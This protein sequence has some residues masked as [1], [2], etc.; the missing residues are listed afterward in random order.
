M[1]THLFHFSYKFKLKWRLKL[2]EHLFFFLLWLFFFLFLFAAQLDVWAWL[3]GT[4]AV[5]GVLYTCVY[6]LSF[7]LQLSMF[8]M[9]K[10]SRNKIIIMINIKVI[11]TWSK[12]SSSMIQNVKFNDIYHLITFERNQSINV[13][14]QA[15]TKVYFLFFLKNQVHSILSLEYRWDEIKRVW[16][17]S[18]QHV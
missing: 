8:H 10:H 15:N 17:S 3:F 12:M 1:S 4:C 16:D 13:C 6:I 7:S 5:L 14:M 2:Y 11:Q 9:E 18:A